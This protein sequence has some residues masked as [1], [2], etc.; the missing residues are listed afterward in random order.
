[1]TTLTKTRLPIRA[2]EMGEADSLPLLYDISLPGGDADF[3]LDED[4][5]LFL[6]YGGM[7][8]AFPYRSQNNYSRALTRDGIDAYVL[9][10][11]HLRA[12]FVPE[13]GGKLW[14]LTDLDTGRELLFSNHV[15][16][17]AY[18][19]LRNA[20]TSGGVEWNC[21]AVI[22]HHPYTCSLIHTATLSAEESGLGCPVL[23]FY[24]FERIRAVTQQ[25]DFYL[26]EGARFL[27]CR[28]RVVNENRSVTPM[29]WWSNIA[30]KSDPAAR[31]VVP[32]DAAFTPV[33]GLVS[34][35][36]VPVRDGLDVTYPTNN[37]I[38]ID[39][40]F[41]TYEN[42]RHYTT[43]IGAD[44]YGLAE[45]STARL[46]GRKL[47]VW[48]RGQGGAKW[49]EF[50]SGDD[51]HGGYSDGRYCEIQCGLA[52][53]QYECL[54]MPPKT[55]WEWLELYGPI[56]A[57]PAKIHGDWRGAQSEVCRV[58][59]ETAPLGGMED[60][61]RA[62]RK[63]ALTPAKAVLH[64]D[65]A[66]A[67]ENARRTA[68]GWSALSPH[69]DFGSCGEEEAM[70]LT[71]LRD[72]SLRGVPAEI[73]SGATPPPSYQ[74]RPE[75]LSLLEN[76]AA[77]ADRYFWLTHYLLGCAYLARGEAGRAADALDESRRLSENAWNL[78]AASELYRIRGEEKKAASAILAAA[79]LA[80]QNDSLC[81]MTARMLYVTESWDALRA[82][83]AGV[84]EEQRQLPRIRLYRAA[85]AV[86]AGALEEAEAILFG[87]GGLEVPD[88]Q[89]CE[90]SVTE[91]WFS[92]E[93]A[94]A[95]RDIRPFDRASARPPKQFDFRMNV[96]EE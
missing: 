90:I 92:L 71:L 94:K 34:K 82:F 29:Y 16:R 84:S 30:V 77:G 31:C 55:A 3:R 37:P 19:A 79:R 17:P 14:S 28:M 56:H 73:A 46:K 13:C 32:A 24:S 75:W 10:N 1:M 96:A 66:A 25:M 22:G 38:A 91:L 20:W 39:Y 4:D 83:C 41:K 76:A 2:V 65:G 95:K 11:E 81:K 58:L 53:T 35:V 40:F 63:M 33:D 45:T 93:E 42:G 69:L 86:H 21:G 67:L 59:D 8:T 72:G 57:D 47:F 6:N 51:G 9:E 61:L 49:Q 5:G 60:E 43:H 50:L 26:P 85:A 62:T 68:A 15:L 7:R 18:L 12:A 88:I 44:G 27:H 52:N 87:G 70:W 89:E 74:L 54:P 23:R 36:P 78:Y 48:G 80:P 64:G